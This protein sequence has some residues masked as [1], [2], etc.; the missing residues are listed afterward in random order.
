MHLRAEIVVRRFGSAVCL[1]VLLLLAALPA[2]AADPFQS[3]H[4]SSPSTAIATPSWMAGIIAAAA[5]VQSTL[6]DTIS[7]H[8]REVTATHS[9]RALAVIL[10]LSFVYGILHAVGPG[11]GKVVVASYLMTRRERLAN[12]VV[13][14]SL[15][16]LVQGV[17]AIVIVGVLALV[18]QLGQLR[19][20]DQTTLIEAV[21]Y[22]FIALIGARMFYQAATG[23]SHDH[24]HHHGGAAGHHGHDHNG[25]GH[26]HDAAAASRRNMV[27]L[28]LAAGLTPCA[29]AIIVM[30][31]ALANHAFVI[32]IESAM[33]MSA[34][35]A[36][37]VSAI[38]IAS[39]FARQLLQ[40]AVAGSSL[41]SLALERGLNLGGSLLLV[42]FAGLL[43]LG[44][45]SRL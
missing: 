22:A 26:H 30:L 29:S 28:A 27:G 34:G 40:R 6:N 31:F 16:S 4:P 12:G 14:G 11:H 24:H 39:I 25:D 5:R 10:A 35:M 7:D 20:I 41:G 8:I 3:G 43:F 42:V 19:V 21:S 36:I 9:M 45:C 38:G 44:A 15:I 37:T 33:A 18:L 23:R 13:V 1:V 32:G 17:S 2:E